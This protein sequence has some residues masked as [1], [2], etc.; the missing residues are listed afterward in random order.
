MKSRRVSAVLSIASLAVIAACGSNVHLDAGQAQATGDLNQGLGLTTPTPGA[1]SPADGGSTTNPGVNSDPTDSGRSPTQTTG[2]DIS[3]PSDSGA[4]SEGPSGVGVTASS[5]TIGIS[6]VSNADASNQALGANFSTG[7]L[8]G[9]IDAVIAHINA[10]GGVAGRK[11][12]P[13][14]HPVDGS[15]Q[16]KTTDQKAQEACTDYTQDHKVFATF[17]SAVNDNFLACMSKTGIVIAGYEDAGYSSSDFARY[18][19][20]FDVN[21]L[22]GDKSF[23]HLPQV[24][25]KQGWYSGWDNRGGAPAA[26]ASLPATIGVLSVDY[27]PLKSATINQL[28]PGL[29]A[30]GHPV[31]SGNVVYLHNPSNQAGAA[32]VITEI[33]SAVLRFRS[34]GVTHV[35][36]ADNAGGVTYF[37]A[38]AAESQGYRPRYGITT[39]NQLQG[40]LGTKQINTRQVAG[41]MGLGFAPLAD[42]PAAQNPDASGPY[43]NATRKLC[44]SIFQKA[45]ITFPDDNSKI[46][47][48]NYCDKLLF[49][50]T[51]ANKVKGPLTREAFRTAADALGNE[52]T[53]AALQRARF[54]PGHHWANTV[55]YDLRYD[56]T[57]TCMRYYGAPFSVD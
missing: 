9:E 53:P 31:S 14:F 12:T 19:F 8:K 2:S 16:N 46:I 40:F 30:A 24:F 3:V 44:L 45:R 32:Q 49:F 42:L 27:P 50:A 21:T 57:C 20:F 35:I 7:N 26:T 33:A 47:A 15:D 6:N 22:V 36:I 18:P 10:T 34:A 17:D 48:F 43:T 13:Y 1:S 41:A 38:T 23:Q 51:T 5:V 4:T 56:K 39:A 29:K 11:L 37:F 55:G 52:F 28:L 25:S 54:A